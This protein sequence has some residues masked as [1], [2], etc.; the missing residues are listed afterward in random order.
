MTNARRRFLSKSALGLAAAAVSPAASAHAEPQAPP[1]PPPAGM[2]PAFGTG[3]TV[4]PEITPATLAE[5]EKLVQVQYT[6][7][8]RAQAAGNWRVSMAPLYERRTGPRKVAIPE[9]IA[10]ASRWDPAIPGVDRRSRARSFR[11]QRR[12]RGA[13]P[14]RDEDIAFARVRDSS[15]WIESRA[16]TSER[17]TRIYL[18]RLERFQPKINATITLTRDL[19]LEQAR[20]ADAEIAAGQVSRTAARHPLG[21]EGSRRHRRHPHHL[22]S[23]A[24]PQ[25]RPEQGRGR[26]SIACIARAR[27]WWPSSAW[28]R[29]R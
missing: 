28:A 29:W 5:A 22:R 17:L 16:L 24:V 6:A 20:R 10:P 19:A 13:L 27:C 11:A 2:P 25:P 26:S 7:A 9:T 3:P 21:R 23:R 18:E 1:A 14:A 4:G 15:R 8:E 12:P